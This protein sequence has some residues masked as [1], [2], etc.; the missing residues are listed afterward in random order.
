MNSDDKNQEQKPPSDDAGLRKI[1]PP[2]PEF[3]RRDDLLPA[4]PQEWRDTFEH[5]EVYPLSAQEE[6]IGSAFVSLL[7]D[8]PMPPSRKPG[9]TIW[10]KLDANNSIKLVFVFKESVPFVEAKPLAENGFD[11][12]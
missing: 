3:F 7:E 1:L 2:P 8:F 6:K 10:T 9:H 5:V 12:S 4:M 11:V